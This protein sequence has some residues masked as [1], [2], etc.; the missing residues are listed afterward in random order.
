MQSC[1]IN[2]FKDKKLNKNS[3]YKAWYEKY[4]DGMQIYNFIS[5]YYNDKPA[6]KELPLS[7]K[8]Y[9]I[10]NDIDDIPDLKFISFKKG[11]IKGKV[12]F[13]GKSVITFIDR[14]NPKQYCSGID[15]SY[16]DTSIQVLSY[17]K[18]ASYTSLLKDSNLI[19]NVLKHTEDV[20]DIKFKFARLCNDSIYCTCG[21][22]RSFKNENTFYLNKTCGKKNC[23]S[24]SLSDKIKERD[25]SYLQSDSVKA[26]RVESRRG[27]CHSD[28]TKSKISASNK[29]TWTPEKRLEQTDIN[30]KA[31]VYKKSSET[32]RRKILTGE[33]TPNVNNRYSHKKL[34]SK[35]TC[36]DNYRSSWEVTFHETN[37]HLE[38]ETVRIPYTY[39][40]KSRVYIVDFNDPIKREL[41]EVKPKEF[42]TQP[43]N[44]AKFE[45]ARLWCADNEYT[46]NIITE[47][48]ICKKI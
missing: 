32:M 20:K 31:G 10:V 42:T 4:E 19:Y 1:I 22:H 47:E 37:P 6:L 11:Y 13:S 45:A 8:L 36:L 34:S 35:I 7:Q 17:I 15:M 26:K 29:N 41:Y 16:D 3:Y 30:K 40:G 9:H 21:K 2:F 39:D 5:D 44:K 14:L 48:H 43:L 24:R 28:T 33:F 18:K 27:Y 25:L 12:T 23:I 38:Y 46:F